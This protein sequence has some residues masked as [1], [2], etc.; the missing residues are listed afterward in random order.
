MDSKRIANERAQVMLYNASALHQSTIIIRKL[1]IPSLNLFK[2]PEQSL[3]DLEMGLLKL[4]GGS[5]QGFS[6]DF[7]YVTHEGYRSNASPLH[8]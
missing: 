4:P 7:G 2:I 5:H 6:P 1:S 8:R 3:I